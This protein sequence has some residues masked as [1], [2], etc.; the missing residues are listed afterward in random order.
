MHVALHELLGHGSGKDLAETSTG[1]FNFNRETP[2][3]SPLTQEPI[4]SWYA[5]GQT[6]KALFGT[7]YEECRCECVALY[8][9]LIEDVW[10]AFDFQEKHKDPAESKHSRQP[11]K[12]DILT[13]II[14]CVRRL[15]LPDTSGPNRPRN[16][17]PKD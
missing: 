7:S 13:N 4:K 2:P 12:L 17:E 16:L 11:V 10:Q 9:S 14:S 15:R 3:I 5:P 8:L 6:W 1:T